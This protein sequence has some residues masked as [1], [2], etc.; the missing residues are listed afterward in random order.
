MKYNINNGREDNEGIYIL[1][2]DQLIQYQLLYNCKN[3]LQLLLALQV[4]HIQFRRS[5]LYSRE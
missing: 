3:K 4:E 2:N 5:L 1:I